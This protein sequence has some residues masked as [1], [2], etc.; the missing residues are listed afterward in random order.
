MFDGLIQELQ[1]SK[2]QSSYS[3]DWSLAHVAVKLR[4]IK[5]WRRL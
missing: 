1:S 4:W 2:F 3:R 5:I